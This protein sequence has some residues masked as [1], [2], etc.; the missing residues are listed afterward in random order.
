MAVPRLSDARRLQPVLLV[1][2]G[3]LLAVSTHSVDPR[4][5]PSTFLV[6]LRLL[7]LATLIAV[8]GHELARDREPAL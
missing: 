4:L 2:L 6:G 3:L 5:E 1:K 7:D 8:E